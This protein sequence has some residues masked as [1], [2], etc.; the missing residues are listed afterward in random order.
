MYDT[1]RAASPHLL[2]ES[3]DT[4]SIIGLRCSTR[5]G[6]FDDLVGITAILDGM[7]YVRLYPATTDPG[8]PYLR[9]PINRLGTAILPSGYHPKMFRRGLHKGRYRA[10]VQNTPV[11]LWRDD[12]RDGLI[13]PEKLVEHRRRVGI[14]LHRA[15]SYWGS[16]R[17]EELLQLTVG[18]WSAGCQVIASARHFEYLMWFVEELPQRYFDYI[19]L[20]NTRNQVLSGWEELDSVGR[21]HL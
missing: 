16:T 7:V 14:N 12:D 18:R 8:V 20:D 19:L 10:L 21:V 6:R 1:L 17:A 9:N 3:P 15:S 13:D 11:A 5:S 2:P 4:G